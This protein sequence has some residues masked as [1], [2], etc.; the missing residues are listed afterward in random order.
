MSGIHHSFSAAFLLSWSLLTTTSLTTQAVV[1]IFST[2]IWNCS[3]CELIELRH[4]IINR[5][6]LK[7]QLKTFSS[8]NFIYYYAK[9]YIVI[10][11]KEAEVAPNVTV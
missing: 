5:S 9:E 6:R 3:F 8:S 4:I 10:F 11:I 7:I 1:Q 2:Q